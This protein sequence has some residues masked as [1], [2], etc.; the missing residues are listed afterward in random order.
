[1]EINYT[2]WKH[3]LT[4]LHIPWSK[5]SRSSNNHF[6]IKL[7]HSLEMPNMRS[8][9]LC[10]YIIQYCLL[11]RTNR[12]R[13]NSFICSWT[14]LVFINIFLHALSSIRKQRQPFFPPPRNRILGILTISLRDNQGWIIPVLLKTHSYFEGIGKN[15]DI[16]MRQN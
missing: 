16:P 6:L 9:V 8:K 14:L 11:Q 7:Y 15:Y 3:F 13:R 4:L 5:S 12:A 1:M 10:I 2:A